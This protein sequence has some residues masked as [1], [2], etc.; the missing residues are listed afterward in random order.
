LLLTHISLLPLNIGYSHN[1]VNFRPSQLQSRFNRVE[2]GFA[3]AAQ[4]GLGHRR[5][6]PHGS[7][8]RGTGQDSADLCGADA[9]H[10]ADEDLHTSLDVQALRQAERESAEE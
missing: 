1:I 6:Q 7:P 8:G 2:Q 10:V 9:E 3:G 4:W 5:R